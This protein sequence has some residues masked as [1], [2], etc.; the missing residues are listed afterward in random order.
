MRWAHR[1]VVSDKASMG[2]P[3]DEGGNAEAGGVT[4]RVPVVLQ[5]GRPPMRA[6][7]PNSPP[8]GW[9]WSGFNGAALR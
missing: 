9:N 1:S 2:P 6:E 7:T 8:S 4:V 3:S 5:W